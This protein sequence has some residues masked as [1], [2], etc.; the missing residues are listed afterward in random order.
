MFMYK[1][2]LSSLVLMF[3]SLPM[4]NAYA[5]LP[6]QLSTAAIYRAPKSSA[7]D[8]KT[9]HT[10]CERMLFEGVNK[11]HRLDQFENDIELHPGEYLVRITLATICGS[12][13]HT[14]EGRRTS[15]LPS[16]LG[17]EAVGIV[18]AVGEGLDENLVGKRV[19][20]TITDTCGSCEYCTYWN[21]PQKCENVFKYGHSALEDGSGLNGCFSSHILLRA[22]THIVVLPDEV[23]DDVMAP[24][25]CALA[26]MVAVIEAVPADT[27]NVFIQGAGLLGVYGVALLKHKGV[28]NVWVTDVAQ[29]R[30][31]VV[32]KFGA[33]VIHSSELARLRTKQFDVVIEVAGVSSIISDGMRL[34]RLGG[35]YLWAGMVHDQTPLDILGVDV[36]KGCVTII[37]IH[38]YAA[39][40]LEEAVAFL[41]ETKD[42]FPWAELVSDPMALR[43]LDDAF[44]MTKQ[45]KWHR[46]SVKP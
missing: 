31:E 17:H 18:E 11:G 25:N 16:V 34:L 46:V 14:Y 4:F 23:P 27:K 15:F 35:I 9:V 29:Q 13:L 30:L 22:G 19:T 21:L 6:H 28:E 7:L 40:H 37:G 41:G 24:A 44:T 42:R 36:V 12:D 39:K 5:N 8:I 32:E 45:R 38:N 26:T 3:F 20:W 10:H 1:G 43:A 33:K 2:L